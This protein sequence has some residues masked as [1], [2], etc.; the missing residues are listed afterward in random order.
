MTNRVEKSWGYYEDLLRSDEKVIKL[1]TILQGQ[2]ISNQKHAQRDEDWHIY[3][4]RGQAIIDLDGYTC[5]LDLEPGETFTVEAGAWHQV[6]CNDDC[7]SLKAV[8]IQ[9][10]ACCPK[11]ITNKCL[12]EDIERTDDVL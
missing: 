1:L 2:K 4:G 11:G 8:E 6:K 12:E 10:A 5:I 9:E 7:V 3:S